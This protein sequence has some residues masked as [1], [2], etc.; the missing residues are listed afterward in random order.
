LGSGALAT[1]SGTNP[2]FWTQYS[3]TYIAATTSPILQFGFTTNLGSDY[4]LDTVSVTDASAPSIELLNNPSFDNST[5]ALNG[6]VVWCNS[7][8]SAGA[9]AQV[10]FGTNCYLSIG[11]CFMADCPDTGLGAV[12]FLGQSFSA[13]IGDTY[14]ISFRLR[15]AY[16][17]G[18]T[19]ATL[20]TAYIN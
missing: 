9:G 8:C 1:Q 20:F 3:Y 15:L 14:T 6:W 19:S 10:L 2:S 17:G 18:G 13:I 5:T 7:T 11:N 12:V 16:G 4:F